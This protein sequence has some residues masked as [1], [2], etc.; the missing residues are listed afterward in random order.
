MNLMA[1]LLTTDWTRLA[2]G[3]SLVLVFGGAQARLLLKIAAA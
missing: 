1:D 2:P 3:A